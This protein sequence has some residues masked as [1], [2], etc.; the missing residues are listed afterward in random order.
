MKKSSKLQRAEFMPKLKLA[1]DSVYTPTL[2]VYIEEETEVVFYDSFVRSIG[3]LNIF[4][5]RADV[6]P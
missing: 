6:K 5:N 1:F 2:R 3:L 4:G